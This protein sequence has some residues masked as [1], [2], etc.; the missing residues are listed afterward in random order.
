[1]LY[2]PMAKPHEQKALQAPDR[3]RHKPS[4]AAGVYRPAGGSTSGLLS[5]PL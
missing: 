1:M 4:H 2:K 5:S 3:S